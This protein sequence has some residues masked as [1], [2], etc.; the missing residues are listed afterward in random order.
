MEDVEIQHRLRREGR[1]KKSKLA[2]VTSGRR[3][4]KNGLIFQITVDFLLVMLFKLGVS[5]K[6]LKKYYPDNISSKN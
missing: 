4:Q 1:F 3:F 6:R 2:V 5:P